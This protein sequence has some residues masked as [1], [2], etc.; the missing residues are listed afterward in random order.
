[1]TAYYFLIIHTQ[2]HFS[3]YTEYLLP[4]NPQK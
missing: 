3:T 2:Q 1:M 4:S